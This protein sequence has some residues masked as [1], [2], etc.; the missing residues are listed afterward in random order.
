M[1][2]SNSFVSDYEFIQDSNNKITGA[3][4]PMKQHLVKENNKKMLLGGSIETGMTRF[5]NL[6]IPAGLYL[7]NHVSFLNQTETP[8]KNNKSGVIENELF[9]KLFN[10][11]STIKS[12]PGTRKNREPLP[13]N[14]TKQKKN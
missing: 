3:I 4:Y 13:K 11:V 6:G 12:H 1:R 2:I 10:T 9:D 14:K 7:E 8:S 5:D